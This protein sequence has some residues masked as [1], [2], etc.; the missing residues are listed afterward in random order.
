MPHRPYS[1]RSAAGRGGR[2]RAAYFGNTGGLLNPTSISGL[3]AWYDFSDITSLWQDTG[4]TSAVTADG[5]SIKGVTDK[6]GGGLD[7]TEATA[8]PTYKAS[9]QNG[10]SIARF[11]AAS[12]N[13][14]TR[15]LT[16]STSQ[17]FTVLAVA[18]ATASAATKVIFNGNTSNHGMFITA[19]TGTLGLIN[20]SNFTGSTD[21]TGAFHVFSGLFNNASSQIWTDGASE[22]TGSIGSSLALAGTRLGIRQDGSSPFGGDIAEVLLY[23]S[24]SSADRATVEAYLKARWG[25]P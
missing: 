10:R 1:P 23:S 7:L 22:A 25:T 19:T 8:P 24:M 3:V 12:S 4:L 17:P 18:K 2:S 6:S 21:R 11:A 20:T 15:A 13:K 9:I 5:Q 16:P 14:L